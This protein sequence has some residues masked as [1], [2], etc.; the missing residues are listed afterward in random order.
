MTD[1][2]IVSVVI[3]AYNAARTI[4]ETV[5]SVLAQ[6]FRRFELIIVN[7]GSADRTAEIIRTR[8]INDPRVSLIDQKNAG[9]AAARNAGI[10]AARSTLIAPIDS[11]DLWHPTY[12]EKQVGTLQR[13]PRA[14]FVYAWSR[15]IDQDSRILWTHHYSLVTGRALCQ[16]IY[17]NF[18]ANGSAMV[19]RKS[20]ALDF[21]AYDDRAYAAEDFLLQVK[22]AS[23]HECAVTPEYLVG[24]RSHPGQKTKN[25]NQMVGRLEIL[26]IIR[27]ECERVPDEVINW[28]ISQLYFAYM[29]E[30]LFAGHG[31]NAVELLLRAWQ[32]DPVG[33]GYRI[34]SSLYRVGRYLARGAE[35]VFIQAGVAD[36]G[37]FL[38][39][40]TVD[41]VAPSRALLQNWRL[42][43]LGKLD[44]R[45]IS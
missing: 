12:L 43:Y 20:A 3:P 45:D 39:A 21:G 22:L 16:L 24:Y 29:E 26:R 10:A 15:Y 9:T 35:R 34:L 8:F 6:T 13:Y 19:F 18:V 44:K 42:R 4:E 32:N 41:F 27:D 36:K 31:K 5:S 2:P 40:P 11:D 25:P 14:G 28:K 37:P 7:D 38:E 1:P 30:A 23:Q 33:T 17:W